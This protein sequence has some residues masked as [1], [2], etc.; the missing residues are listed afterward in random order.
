MANTGTYSQHPALVDLP[1]LV[2]RQRTLEANLV[3][4]LPLIDDEKAIRSQIDRLLVEAGILPGDAVT[5]NGY[6]VMHHLRAGS[7][8]LNQAVL[9]AQLIAGGVDRAFVDQVIA[10][11]TQTGEPSTWATVKPSKGSR[12]SATKKPAKAT[13]PPKRKRA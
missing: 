2:R 12:V 3:D 7:T 9:I 6:D 5:C 8:R 1:P 11:S 13:L 4:L 10:V